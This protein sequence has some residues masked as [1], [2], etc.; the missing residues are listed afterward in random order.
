MP[1]YRTVQVHTLSKDFRVATKIVEVAELPTATAGKIVVKNH[2]VGINAT[3]INITNGA[4]GL[5]TLPFG[6][7]LEAAGIV[8][9]V[10]EGVTNVSV[11]DA[12]TYQRTFFFVAIDIGCICVAYVC[13]GTDICSCSVALLQN[14]ARSPSTRLCQRPS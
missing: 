13:E 4:Y 1:S 5:S 12:V 2:F 8:T 11:G 6:C 9:A 3:D 7:G 10:G 14:L